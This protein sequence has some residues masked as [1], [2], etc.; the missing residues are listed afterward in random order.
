MM[1]A[2]LTA[3]ATPNH[4]VGQGCPGTAYLSTSTVTLPASP[5][6][7]SANPINSTKRAFHATP[8]PEYEYE[9][10]ESRAFSMELI[11]SMPRTL[12]RRGIQSTI[13]TCTLEV[14]LAVLEKTEASRKVKKPRENYSD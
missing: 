13:V 8:E 2:L 5:P 12:Q 6:A 10:A 11:T 14:P 3:L 4:I 1:S 9:S 7:M